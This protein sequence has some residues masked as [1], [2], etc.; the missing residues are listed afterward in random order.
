MVSTLSP[1]IITDC[2][3]L[4][5]Y[6]FG[7]ERW[8]YRMSQRNRT[9]LERYE[10]ENPVMAIKTEEDAKKIIADFVN[11][12]KKG[13]HYF[14]G[15]F[16]KEPEQF[17]AQLYIGLVNP[18]VNEYGIGFFSDVEHE[19]RGFVTEAVNAVV[20]SLFE[21]LNAHRIRIETDDT[22]VRSIG[23]AERCGFVREGHIRENKKNPDGTY[24]GTL[25]YG[26]LR[27]EFF[28]K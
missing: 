6:T 19:G 17:V 3:I 20:K 4:R 24:S 22:N 16:L 9:H 8:Y 5:S 23:V 1:V 14:M 26:L 27:S 7:D 12:W 10:S 21:M 11:E 25:Y 28:A 2:L 15:V 13:S 18:N